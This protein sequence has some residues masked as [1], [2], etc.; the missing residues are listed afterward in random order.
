MKM[1]EMFERYEVCRVAVYPSIIFDEL[2][3]LTT[4][5]MVSILVTFAKFSEWEKQYCHE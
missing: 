1:S 4:G 2:W 3:F 5:P